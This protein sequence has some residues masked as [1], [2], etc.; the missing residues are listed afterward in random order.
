M[1]DIIPLIHWAKAHGEA[2]IA[3]RILVKLL[4]ELLQAK[5]QITAEMLETE[6]VIQVPEALFERIQL[7]AEELVGQSYH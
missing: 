2:K 1:K 7:L 6:S 5:Q 4:P 3:D